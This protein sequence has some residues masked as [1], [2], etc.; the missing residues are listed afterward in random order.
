MSLILDGTNGLT[1]NN[2]T[3]QNSG[4]K[5]I[6]VQSTTF[7]DVFTASLTAGASTAITGFSVSITPLSSS[8]KILV[9]LSVIGSRYLSVGGG[10]YILKRNGTVVLAGTAVGSR[11]AVTTGAMVASDYAENVLNSNMTGLDTPATTSALTYQVFVQ[12]NLNGTFT[13]QINRTGTDTDA[14]YTG[15]YISTITVMEVAG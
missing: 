8:S 1:F 5:V 6:Q 3:T 7:S 2:A 9:F 12:S 14:A 10:N 13:W 15:R 11:T 4:G